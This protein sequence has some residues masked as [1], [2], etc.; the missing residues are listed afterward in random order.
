[1]WETQSQAGQQFASWKE[2]AISGFHLRF[3]FLFSPVLW[4]EVFPTLFPKI[5]VT[6]SLLLFAGCF[7]RFW[8]LV[9]SCALPITST[10]DAD[11]LQ[12]VAEAAHKGMVLG[13]WGQDLV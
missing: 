9:V 12:Q 2:A 11:R 7:T 4:Y 6:M 13:L 5:R 10:E 8:C 1:M 3:F